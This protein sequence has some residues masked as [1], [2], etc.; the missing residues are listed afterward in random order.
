MRRLLLFVLCSLAAFAQ[1]T[2]DPNLWTEIQKIP[3]IDD[4][5]HVMRVTGPG[6]KDTEFDALP[7]EVEAWDIPVFLRPDRPEVIQA[8]KALYGYKYNDQAPEHVKEL[9]AAREKLMQQQG[10]NF[11]TWVLDHINTKV[12]CPTMMRF[13]FR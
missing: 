5:T 11:P 13:C 7:C 9:I 2:P 3:A 6:E 8:W 12:M 1:S 4:H 10:D